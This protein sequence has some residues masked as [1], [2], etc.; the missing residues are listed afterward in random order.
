M[1]G[2]RPLAGKL[3]RRR[4]RT[5]KSRRR[6]VRRG[7]YVRPPEI[8]PTSA[9]RLCPRGS[10]GHAAP[11]RGVTPASDANARATF[12]AN[13][14]A[15]AGAGY[16]TGEPEP[17]LVRRARGTKTPQRGSGA[18]VE[19]LSRSQTGLRASFAA[20]QWRD[21]S[22]RGN[23]DPREPTDERANDERADGR[24]CLEQ[25]ARMTR[26]ELLAV[27]CSAQFI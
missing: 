23:G 8:K 22:P 9:W 18:Q 16:V 11:V 1:K 6:W 14:G 2:G 26:A 17:G 20:R 5:V 4:S 13:L 7:F 25:S 27:Y 15:A 12:I 19:S 21:V 24:T 10:A 3:S